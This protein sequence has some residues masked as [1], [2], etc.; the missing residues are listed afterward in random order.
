LSAASFDD[1]VWGSTG[2][3]YLTLYSLDGYLI[4]SNW[5]IYLGGAGIVVNDLFPASSP[6]THLTMASGVL[7][8]LA[9]SMI[10]HGSSIDYQPQTS[11]NICSPSGPGSVRVFIK[12]PP[13]DLY[14]LAVTLTQGS[15]PNG[16]FY[17]IAIPFSELIS[18]ALTGAPFLGSLDS[19][20]IASIGPFG[21][22]PAGMTLYAVAVFSPG[23]VFN[24]IAN[25]NSV[26]YAVP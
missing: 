24:P 7:D 18:E 9:G 17:G 21:G 22:L 2:I 15:Y 6:I 23:P 16:W 4:L 5:R 19:F 14:F 25:S 3:N 1:P 20:G 13:S 26:A 11:L 10:I 12:G 8:P